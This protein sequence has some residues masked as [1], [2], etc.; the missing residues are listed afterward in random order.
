MVIVFFQ[1]LFLTVIVFD[2]SLKFVEDGIS[3][4][5]WMGGRVDFLQLTDGHL[6][7]NLRC[8]EVGVSEQLLDESDVGSVLVHER[9][10]GVPEQMARALLA[11]FGGLHVIADKLRQS[12][13]RE[14]LV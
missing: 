8:R 13:R 6:R 12:V 9:S 3:D 1:A 2:L 10:T 4:F 7:V 14:R 11:D 5:G